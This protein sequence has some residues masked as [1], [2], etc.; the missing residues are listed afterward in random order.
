M[1]DSVK[2]RT[3]EAQRDKSGGDLHI[4]SHGP[5]SHRVS[6]GKGLSVEQ[7][8]IDRLKDD[9]TRDFFIKAME[10]SAEDLEETRDIVDLKLRKSSRKTR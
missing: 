6:P 7:Y 2:S 5:I 8:M 9:T 1:L 10:L 4:L 3:V